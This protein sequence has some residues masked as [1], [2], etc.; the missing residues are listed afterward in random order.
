MPT[1]HLAEAWQFAAHPFE[2]LLVA[3]SN[4]HLLTASHWNTDSVNVV[5]HSLISFYKY[6]ITFVEDFIITPSGG[7][8]TG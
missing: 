1:I 2:K 6:Q 7:I 3:N 4:Q 5:I 8:T